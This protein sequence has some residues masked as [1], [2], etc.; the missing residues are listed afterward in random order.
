MTEQIAGTIRVGWSIDEKHL[1]KPLAAEH[2]CQVWVERVGDG[3][4]VGIVMEDG[5]V[6][7]VRERR[8]ENPCDASDLI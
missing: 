8:K 7:E 2:D 3:D 4:E 1:L 5:E 6:R